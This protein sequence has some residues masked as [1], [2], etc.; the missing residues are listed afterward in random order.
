[1]NALAKCRM[2]FAVLMMLA[3]FST[4]TL[5]AA[6]AAPAW[7]GNYHA[8]AVGDVVSYQGSEYRCIQ[9]HTSL[10]DWTPAAVPALWEK[11]TTSAT[12]T[13]KPA[14]ATPKPA[15]AVP[16]ATPKPGS[17][18]T[19]EPTATAKPATPTS[20]PSGSKKFVGYFTEW[21][22][23][24]RNYL[25]KNIVT[26]GSASKLTHINY[27]FANVANSQCVIGDAY[28]DYDRAFTAAESV[29]GVADSWDGS[30]RGN[31]NQ[32]RK[33]KAAYP[34]IKVLI[35]LGGWTWSSGFSDAALPANRAA[36]VK[37][38]VDLYIK[39]SRWAGVFDGIDIDWEYPGACGN[40][41][42]YRPEDT[43][44]FTAL[45][46]EFRSQL[47]AVR[48]GLLL[49]IAAPAAPD[50]ISKIEVA[51]ISQSLD[52]I[53]LMTYDFHGG[54]WENQTNFQSNLYTPAADPA[55]GNTRIS[56]D[57]AV[58][59]WINA[60]APAS[61]LVVG[62]PFYGRGWSNVPSAN[63][64]LWQTGSGSPAGTYE[65]GYEDYKVLKTKGYT[66]YFNSEAQ[67]AW[68]YSNGIF[69][70]FDDPAVMAAKMSY[71]KS[72]GLGG[73]MFWDLS[74]DTANGELITALYNNR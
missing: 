63:N 16:T 5:P 66:R 51:K 73:A 7:D 20:V 62:V 52:F 13:P 50:K 31:F 36:F 47:N 56:V 65:A 27:A 37:S 8:Y 1:M 61:K 59:S 64:G 45:L 60:G 54:G 42:N 38:C 14:T 2:F 28:A 57:S 40:T 6:A 39:D 19:A 72:R 74:G 26:S 12:A 53:N 55:T 35:S 34:N 43:A 33:L 4:F 9:A 41:C 49:T 44:N 32:L 22:I 30:L 10:S 70:T 69:W 25:V 67:A 68:L 11:L 15:T 24:Q 18:A 17:T 48:S 23:Y 29:D 46:A 58:S 71:I 3:I 21:G